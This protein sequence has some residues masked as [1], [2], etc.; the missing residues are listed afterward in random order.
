MSCCKASTNL[1]VNKQMY[2]CCEN[3]PNHKENFPNLDE[4]DSQLNKLI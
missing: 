1:E 2:F 4:L 3:F